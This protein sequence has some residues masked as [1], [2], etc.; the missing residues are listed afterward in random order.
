MRKTQ[1]QETAQ[2]PA[3]SQEPRPKLTHQKEVS[4]E[5]QPEQNVAKRG[6][7]IINK[8]QKIKEKYK[9]QDEEDKKLMME[10]L[11]SAKAPKNKDKKGKSKEPEVKKK[12]LGPQHEKKVHQQRENTA[13]GE[14]NANSDEE[15]E[16]VLKAEHFTVTQVDDILDTLTGIPAADDLLLFAIPVCAPYN[17]MQNYK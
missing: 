10:I 12:P 9:D 2:P 8:L 6:K 11:Q 14:A 1:H 7:K 4:I 17:T 3:S 16:L 13:Q 15:K 5:Q